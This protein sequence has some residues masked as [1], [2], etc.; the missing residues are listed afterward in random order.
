[1]HGARDLTSIHRIMRHNQG[2]FGP[3]IDAESGGSELR[4]TFRALASRKAVRQP[5]KRQFQIW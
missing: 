1:L 5:G 3:P 4:S 2:R